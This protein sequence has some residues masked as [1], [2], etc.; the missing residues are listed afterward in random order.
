MEKIVCPATPKGEEK[1]Q[2]R[3][4]GCLLP[5]LALHDKMSVF[6]GK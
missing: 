2:Y 6:I 3:Y 5:S 4:Q 1:V